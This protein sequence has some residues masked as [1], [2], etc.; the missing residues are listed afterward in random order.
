MERHILQK[1][2]GCHCAETDVDLSVQGD[3]GLKA[4]AKRNI[5]GSS[6]RYFAREKWLSFLKSRHSADAHGQQLHTGLCVLWTAVPLREPTF[7]LFSGLEG[8]LQ[9]AEASQ[10][11]PKTEFE[12]DEVW[13]VWPLAIPHWT[14]TT[15]SLQRWWYLW[16]SGWAGKSNSSLSGIQAFDLDAFMRN[17]T[18]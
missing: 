8:W 1:L 12:R 2:V 13:S 10:K 17:S 4:Y 9:Q 15:S 11:W 14:D 16:I 7:L 6:L 5:Q 18:L 3:V